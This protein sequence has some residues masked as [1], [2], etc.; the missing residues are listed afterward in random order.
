MKAVFVTLMFL[1]SISFSA[2]SNAAAGL[3]EVLELTEKYI[4]LCQTDDINDVLTNLIADGSML[5]SR[6][7]KD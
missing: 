1:F 3:N 6:N 2:Q 4:G 5:M 7:P